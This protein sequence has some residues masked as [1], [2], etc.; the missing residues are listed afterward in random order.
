LLFASASVTTGRVILE[1]H[2]SGFSQQT[3]DRWSPVITISPFDHVHA[4]PELC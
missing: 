2:G 3:H 4:A 1:A